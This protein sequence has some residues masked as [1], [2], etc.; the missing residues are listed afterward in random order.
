M[1]TQWRGCLLWYNKMLSGVKMWNKVCFQFHGESQT[2]INY[3]INVSVFPQTEV[4]RKVATSFFCLLVFLSVCKVFPVERNIDDDF[5]ANTPFY[6]QA[7]YLY[8]SMLTTRPKY[9]FVWTLGGCLRGLV[10]CGSKARPLFAESVW[11]HLVHLSNTPPSNLF[12]R[13][14]MPSTMPQASAS[15]AMTV[16]ALLAGTSSPTWGSSTSRSG[17]SGVWTSHHV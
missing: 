12:V 13:Q 7:V 9:Y 6:A 8:L 14:L 11:D 10:S 3:R 1:S 15:T 16:M 5:I 4:V 2:K 17:L